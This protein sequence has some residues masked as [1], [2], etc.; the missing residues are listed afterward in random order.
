MF[1]KLRV[2]ILILYNTLFQKK[3]VSNLMRLFIKTKEL[4]PV[5]TI[6]VWVYIPQTR[7]GFNIFHSKVI[8]QKQTV[9]I[10]LTVTVILQS[11]ISI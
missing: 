3:K 6:F 5:K 1:Q 4:L 2:K 9:K 11:N 10:L 7:N 8:S